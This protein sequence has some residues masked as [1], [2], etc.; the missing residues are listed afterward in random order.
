MPLLIFIE[1]AVFFAERDQSIKKLIKAKEKPYAD[2]G[3]KIIHLRS[4]G[5]WN[6]VFF[7]Q[8]EYASSEA[9]KIN[10]SGYWPVVM[11]GHSMGGPT[12]RYISL[13]LDEDKTTLL[14][15]LDA[16]NWSPEQYTKPDR[17]GEWI[18]VWL[19]TS[20]PF[21]FLRLDWDAQKNADADIR[22][23]RGDMTHY[24]IDHRN[25]EGMYNHYVEDKVLAALQSCP[26]GRHI[27]VSPEKLSALASV[28]AIPE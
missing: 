14:V 7:W 8:P 6:W 16:M 28:Y 27:Q 9:A 13:L 15:T 24:E 17:A 1:G 10:T 23:N 26:P 21:K 4:R 22:I 20:A 12:A 19:P 2:K 5:F 25:A 3:I 18:N 11:V